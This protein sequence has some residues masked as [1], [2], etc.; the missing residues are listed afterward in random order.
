MM[1]QYS[2][3]KSKYPDCVLLFR[4]GDFYEAFDDDARYVSKV[5]GLVLTHRSDHPMAG[6]PHH[7]LGIY[8]KKLIEQGNKVAICD[9][10]EDP[11]TA[12]GIVKRDVTRVV[13]PGTLIDEDILTES[14][15]YIA[16]FYKD[17]VSLIDI[18]TGDFFLD[19]GFEAIERYAP[20]HVIHQGELDSLEGILTERVEDWYFDPNNSAQTIKDH[21]KISDISFLELTKGEEIAASA[22]LKYLDITQKRTLKNIRYPLKIVENE[23]VFLDPSTISNLEILES[24]SGISLYSHMK[25]TVTG[26][27]QRLLKRE[28]ISPL[29][30]VEEIEERFELVEMLVNNSRALESL[31]EILSRIQDIE[32]IVSRVAY[33]AATPSDLVALRESIELFDTLNGWIMSNGIFKDSTLDT[34]DTLEK[35]LKKAIADDPSGNIGDGHVIAEGFSKELDESRSILLDADG[36]I[37][38]YQE[39]EK[40]RLGN[41]IKVGYSS[42]FGYYIEIS[43]GYRGEIPSEYVRKQTLVNCERYTTPELSEIEHK[44]LHASE[45]IK[46]LEIKAFDTV[47]EEILKYKDI[48]TANSS[49]IAFIDMLAS[50]AQIAI[51]EAYVRPTLS[52]TVKIRG[53]RHPIVEKRVNDFVPNDLDIDEKRNFA[54]LT[55]PNMSGKSTFI[56]QTAIIS[57]MAQIGSFV[58]AKKATLKVFDRIFTRIGAKDDLASNRSTFLVEMSEVAT[59]LHSATSNSLIILDEVGRGT[60]TFDGL[61]IAWAVSEYISQR[62]KAFTIFATHY[63]ELSELEKIYS[64]IYNLTIEVAEKG[65]SVLFLHRVVPGMADKSYGIEVARIA[66]IPVEIVNR[67]YEVADALSSASQIK[68]G[69]RFLTAGEVEA[70]KGKL[71]KMN[72]DQMKIF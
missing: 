67:A 61:S 4:L 17:Q 40:N 58:P 64:N 20:S 26:M 48:L 16:A 33:P 47:C 50:F 22:I 70:I 12:K 60:S 59:I 42:V 37:K 8:L 71:K 36:Y 39:K 28:I 66:G 56:R 63:N 51:D 11:A 32:R 43:N 35:F 41:K 27:G 46:A 23:R 19:H 3:I 30:K 24:K 10:L 2:N 68:K 18:S 52:N 34:M 5:L 14:N 65:D 57:L 49:K 53:G 69:V 38:R 7:A 9:Q 62:I 45:T 1:I 15:N 44:V 25:R 72:E 6:I 55:G 29:L 54:I 31:R 21:F 13:T